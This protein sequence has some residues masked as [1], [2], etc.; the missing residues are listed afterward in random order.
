MADL[1]FINNI[2]WVLSGILGFLLMYDF[3]KTE[4]QMAKENKTNRKRTEENGRK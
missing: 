1:S 2:V 4:I 3:I